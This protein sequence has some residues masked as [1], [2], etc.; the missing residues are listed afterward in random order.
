M[1]DPKKLKAD[2]ALAQYAD[3]IVLVAGLLI[4]G[5]YSYFGVVNY[6]PDSSIQ[7][8][9]EDVKLVKENLAKEHSE[10]KPP[11]VADVRQ[12][13]EKSWKSIVMDFQTNDWTASYRTE[14]VKHITTTKAEEEKKIKD[15][16]LWY[17]P[18]LDVT[19]VS[20][21]IDKLTVKWA[22][23]P[24]DQRKDG[25]W[26]GPHRI[27]ANTFQRVILE[28]LAPPKKK[29][30]KA[31][32]EKVAEVEIKPEMKE[33]PAYVDSDIL[34]KSVYAYRAIA[35]VS[36]VPW[37]KIEANRVTSADK[38]VKTLD[39]WKVSLKRVVRRADTQQLV[40]TL[41][42]SKFDKP[43][44]DWFTKEFQITPDTDRPSEKIYL[45]G[46][47]KVDPRSGD[48]TWT[49]EFDALGQT[50]KKKEKIDFNCGFVLQ[51]IDQDA[52]VDGVRLSHEHKDPADPKKFEIKR[53][54]IKY[55]TDVV[56]FVVL[57]ED[58]KV[59]EKHE[60]RRHEAEQEARC[61]VCQPP[62]EKPPEKKPEEKPK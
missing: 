57:G 16:T 1:A 24:N 26:E 34:P 11:E 30:D 22:I 15:A 53:T 18:K 33:F 56:T 21:E 28:R 52:E 47:Y 19:D 27:K 14:L 25:T 31:Q 3:K 9:Q 35:E 44:G 2:E 49:W 38:S 50:G 39:I 5:G 7:R 20:I 32:W 58:K 37:G 29:G 55:R 61:A 17:A 10:H 60:I 62:P 6:K 36:P 23:T 45:G 43:K 13:A 48:L 8:V 12:A 41:D 4:L 46:T 59:L 54:P 40:A 42:L 51:K